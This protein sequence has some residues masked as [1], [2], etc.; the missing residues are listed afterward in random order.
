MP[1]QNTEQTNPAEH[2]GLEEASV[3]GLQ[4]D[5]DGPILFQVAVLYSLFDLRFDN[6]QECCTV[7]AC[8]VPRLAS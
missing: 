1:E 8:L 5:G 2:P 4:L 7:H 6:T 3:S